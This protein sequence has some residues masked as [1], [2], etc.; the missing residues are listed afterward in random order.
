MIN[1][2]FEKID[3]KLMNF[4]SYLIDVALGLYDMF[5]CEDC[6]ERMGFIKNGSEKITQDTLRNFCKFPYL[7]YSE[8]SQY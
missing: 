6:L 7:A 3:R 4:I 1:K 5:V 8:N 2:F